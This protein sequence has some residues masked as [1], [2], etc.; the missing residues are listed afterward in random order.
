MSLSDFS[1]EM[2]EKEL[3]RRKEAGKLVN[4]FTSSYGSPIG[5]WRVT[6]S[7]YTD[8]SSVMDL[9]YH[10][11]HIADIALKL[12]GFS[13]L[14]FQ[15]VTE[16]QE[17]NFPESNN[18]VNIVF[19]QIGSWGISQWEALRTWLQSEESLIP[20]TVSFNN[21]AFG[22]RIIKRITDDY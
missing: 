5:L 4:Q 7:P 1:T 22:A 21:Y 11:G 12:S 8:G 19:N 6:T 3:E 17:L 15:K 14:D 13:K 18:E 20:F 10:Q 2:L 16:C 9:G